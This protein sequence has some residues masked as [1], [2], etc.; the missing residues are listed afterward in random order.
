MKTTGYTW[1]YE[2]TWYTQKQAPELS[3]DVADAIS[4]KLPKLCEEQ[5][6]TLAAC[7]IY[8]EQL[9]FLVAS[10]T[11]QNISKVLRGIQK[12]LTKH[13]GKDFPKIALLGDALWLDRARVI[14]DTTEPVGEDVRIQKILKSLSEVAYYDLL[15]V[16]GE[17][18]GAFRR[19]I[20]SK[21][22][23]IVEWG[24]RMFLV[25]KEALKRPINLNCFECTKIYK[26]GCCCGSPCDYGTRN[27]KVFDQHATGVAKA[28]ET[29]E[30]DHYDA[31][32]A[33]GGMVDSE[34][35]IGEVNGRCALLVAHEGVYKCIAHKYGLDEGIPIY[36]VCPLSCLLYPLEILELITDKQKKVLLFTSV[37]ED[38]FAKRF[39][40]WGSYSSLDVDLRCL[41]QKAHD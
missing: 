40:R 31:V 21:Q 24:D 23:G 30:K 39:G 15:E 2:I 34:G 10:Q 3:A 12:K 32:M 41:N 22:M 7:D 19:Y 28:L 38:D 9:T 27:K 1:N 37:L 20:A 11:Q 8:P 16:S 17:P 29:I 36:D 4:Y 14:T 33:K 13:I 26:Y 25:D 35:V 18:I 5:G 6:V